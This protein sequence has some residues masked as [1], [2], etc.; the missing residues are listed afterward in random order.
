MGIVWIVCP[1]TGEYVS[2]EIET[3]EESFSQLPGFTLT[4]VCPACGETHAWA[5]MHGTL[6]D[7]TI[8]SPTSH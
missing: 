8:R 4:L 3:D 5:D 7:E 2:T 1:V 6:V